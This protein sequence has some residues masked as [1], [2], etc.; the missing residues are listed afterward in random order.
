MNVYGEVEFIIRI[1]PF[2]ERLF[3]H[4]TLKIK[5]ADSAERSVHII[6]NR[7][8]IQNLRLFSDASRN[9]ELSLKKK[10]VT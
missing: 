6:A 2:K 8:A 4:F 9:S 1:S 10:R 3:T 5:A 7:T